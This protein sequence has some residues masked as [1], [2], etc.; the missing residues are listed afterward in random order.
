MDRNDELIVRAS[1][2]AECLFSE[3]GETTDIFEPTDEHTAEAAVR[4]F[5][6]LFAE[7]RGI[8][9]TVMENAQSSGELVSSDP[10]QGLA[11]I[12]QNADDVEATEIRLLLAPMELLVSPQW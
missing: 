8:A 6:E 4:R 10:L 12:V 3:T 7:L 1:A 9:K 11:E 5:G 2:A